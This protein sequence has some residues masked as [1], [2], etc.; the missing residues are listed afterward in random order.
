MR[1]FHVVLQ[2]QSTKSQCKN[3][4]LTCGE[5]LKIAKSFGPCQT[6][7]NDMARLSHEARGANEKNDELIL[8]SDMQI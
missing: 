5:N 2:V 3:G 4:P 8:L 6:E 1:K 7:Q